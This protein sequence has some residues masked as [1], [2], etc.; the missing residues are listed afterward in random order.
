MINE[1]KP[2][3]RFLLL[4]LCLRPFY[5]ITVLL[6]DL[7][8]RTSRWKPHYLWYKVYCLK[9]DFFSHS[10]VIHHGSQF[11]MGSINIQLR[12]RTF[13][14]EVSTAK[15]IHIE[16]RNTPKRRAF[17]QCILVWLLSQKF[18]SQRVMLHQGRI[19]LSLT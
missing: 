14:R 15:L 1:C 16:R 11:S 9:N 18:Y 4:C 10:G 5:L 7:N 19:G 2:S 3:F 13:L 6:M 17:L 12:A 8:Q